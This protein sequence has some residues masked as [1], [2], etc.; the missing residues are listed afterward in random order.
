[1]LKTTLPSPKTLAFLYWLFRSFEFFQS[2]VLVSWYQAL[3]G[4]SESEYSGFSKNSL[5]VLKAMILI[6]QIYKIKPKY[7]QLGYYI[8]IY[9]Y[10]ISE[11]TVKY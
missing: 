11:I 7:P 5:I 6:P 9:L 8:F 2:D 1:M 10:Y 4:I 3:N